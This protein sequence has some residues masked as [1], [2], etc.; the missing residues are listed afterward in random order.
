MGD[1]LS[2]A[3]LLIHQEQARDLSQQHKLQ[4]VFL[5][6]V[7]LAAEQYERSLQLAASQEH[8]PGLR[9]FAPTLTVNAPPVC[10]QSNKK[11]EG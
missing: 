11:D 8:A 6:F 10:H 1:D 9:R 3:M 4:Q 5:T 7:E 2:Y